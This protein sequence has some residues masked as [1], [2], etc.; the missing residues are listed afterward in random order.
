MA[1]TTPNHP[2]LTLMQREEWKPQGEL[3]ARLPRQLP[4]YKH[5]P[6]DDTATPRLLRTESATIH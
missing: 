3:F 2:M 4:V 5:G 1:H 6:E